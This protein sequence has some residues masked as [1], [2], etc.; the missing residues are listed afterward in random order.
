LNVIHDISRIE[1]ALMVTTVHEAIQK[2]KAAMPPLP[3]DNDQLQ[4]SH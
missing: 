2:A 4:Y 3:I 1:L